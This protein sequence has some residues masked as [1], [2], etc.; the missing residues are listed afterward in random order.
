MGNSQGYISQLF[1]RKH[2]NDTAYDAISQVP[3]VTIDR[4]E[5]L[6]SKVPFTYIV[7]FP[8]NVEGSKTKLD[9][10]FRKISEHHSQQ[11]ST[12][13]DKDTKAKQESSQPDHR[14][15]VLLVP[16]EDLS[17]LAQKPF[18]EIKQG[19]NEIIPAEMKDKSLTLIKTHLRDSGCPL[20]KF[21]GY[22]TDKPFSK[23]ENLFVAENFSAG[24]PRSG[25]VIYQS[26]IQQID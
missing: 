22:Q 4:E 5:T 26:K 9:E 8:N 6:A 14:F 12:S 23:A 1:N 16:V 24:D 18:S 21:I 20:I 2:Y 13:V 7:T 25:K 3:L 11:K 15:N 10:Y 17:T 19:L